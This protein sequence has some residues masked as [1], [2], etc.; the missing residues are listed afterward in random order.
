[1]I[2]LKTLKSAERNLKGTLMKFSIQ[3]RFFTVTQFDILLRS[4]G[5]KLKEIK[6]LRLLTVKRSD[7]LS[8]FIEIYL[9]R[10]KSISSSSLDELGV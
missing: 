7:F 1:M 5:S 6:N 8:C 4:Q 3:K 10:H 9:Y 2:V